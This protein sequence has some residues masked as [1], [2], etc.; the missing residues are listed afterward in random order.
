MCYKNKVVIMCQKQGGQKSKW[1]KEPDDTICNE[2]ASR[3]KNVNKV[4]K[5]FKVRSL[6]KN[7]RRHTLFSIILYLISY[8]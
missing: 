5:V 7:Y 8:F 4:L 2:D 3:S 1:K 6:V